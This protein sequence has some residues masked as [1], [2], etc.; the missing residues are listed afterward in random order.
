MEVNLTNLRDVADLIHKEIWDTNETFKSIAEATGLSPRTISKLNY[1]ETKFP[2]WHTVI[3]LLQHFG[4]GVYARK[5]NIRVLPT[6][7]PRKRAR[8]A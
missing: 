4:Y 7:A 6:A 1:G 8:S 2:R 5:S 3:A